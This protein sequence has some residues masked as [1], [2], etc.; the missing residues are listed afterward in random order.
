MLVYRKR[1][2]E[3]TFFERPEGMPRLLHALLIQRGIASAAEAEAFLS[4]DIS[5][6]RDPMLLSDMDKAV[7]H[8]RSRPGGAS[9]CM[10]I[11]T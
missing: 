3:R 7:S 11:T 2:A 4:P 6:L 8:L 10:A 1:E 9:A 5:L